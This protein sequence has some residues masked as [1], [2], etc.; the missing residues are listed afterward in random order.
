M[1]PKVLPLI[2]LLLVIG[3]VL[4]SGC[5]SQQ[6]EKL[7]EQGAPVATQKEA[8]PVTEKLDSVLNIGYQPSTH[9]LAFMT[10][11]SKGWYNE[12]LAPMGI[13]EVNTYNFPTGAPEMQAML[14][15]DLDI[16]YVGAAPFVTAVANGLD[17]K[18][19]GS[20][21]TQGSDL[22]IR[23][24][25]NYTKPDDLKGLSIATFPA[26]TIQDTILRMWLKDQGIDADKDLKIVGMGPGDATTAIMA[27]KVDAVF[28][29]TP[30]A[31]IIEDAGAGKV[32]VQ[33]G[34]MSPGH[35]C[36][37]L[38]ASG[39]LIRNYPQVTEEILKI[40]Q[41]ASE[42][43]RQNSDEAAGYM[44]TMTGLNR[45]VIMKSLKEWDGQWIADP[46]LI[47]KS[48]D[49]YAVIQSELGYITTNV[50][51]KDLIDTSFWANIPKS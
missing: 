25:L 15:G 7:P 9:M 36:C 41:N 35:A 22:V 40:H 19:I 20:V 23:S 49:D 31:T 46:N 37:V 47:V 6:G 29:A 50:T 38:V 14:A 18:I 26:G 42:Y 30:A 45:S 24:G 8:A 51:K 3:T 12:S 48:V 39:D 44:E 43:N 2:I 17:A 5:T 21:Q 1:K 16:A 10:A 33:S 13:A 34:K 32:I 4:L 28:L 27:G 11:Y